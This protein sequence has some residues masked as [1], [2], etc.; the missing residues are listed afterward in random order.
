MA[1]CKCWERALRGLPLDFLR[2]DRDSPPAKVQ[3]A[4]QSRPATESICFGTLQQPGSEAAALQQQL[5]LRSVDRQVVGW[6]SF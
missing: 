2:I 4:I 5:V 1:V 6:A 3:W